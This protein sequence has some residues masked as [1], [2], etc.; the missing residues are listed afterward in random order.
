MPMIE[1]LPI[2]LDGTRVTAEITAAA[3][4]VAVLLAFASGLARLSRS[5]LLRAASVVYVELFRGSSLLVQLFWLF[6]VLPHFG[7]TFTPFQTAVL[8]LGL[9]IG[10]YGSEVVRG[11]ILAVPPGQTAAGAALGLTGPQ[12]MRWIVLP[13]AVL[14]MLPL[15]GNLLIELLKGTALVSL[16]T[17]SDLTFRAYQLNQAT[18]RTAEIFTMV[19]VI[20]GLLALVIAAAARGLERRLGRHRLA[21]ERV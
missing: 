5:C 6:F 10:A 20:Y 11:A 14:R 7:V 2:L 12:V 21:Q 8:G 1:F 13:Q 18:F 9:N 3:A 17:V 19:L 16:I 15:W 4:V